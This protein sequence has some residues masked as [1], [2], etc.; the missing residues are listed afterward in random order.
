M[1]KPRIRAWLIR[2]FAVGAVAAGAAAFSPDPAVAGSE[3]KLYSPQTGEMFC[4]GDCGSS[5]DFACCN[6]TDV[7]LR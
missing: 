7:P 6:S 4:S 1:A 3:Q 5:G 2:M